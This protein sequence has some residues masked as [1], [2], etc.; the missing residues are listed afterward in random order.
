MPGLQSGHPFAI[1]DSARFT[2]RWRKSSEVPDRLLRIRSDHSQLANT[3]N[4]QT[5]AFAQERASRP[6]M[7]DAWFAT[8][9]QVASD[10]AARS[11]TR[12]KGAACWCRVAREAA[13]PQDPG[14]SVS[15]DAC[16]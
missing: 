9:A 16:L 4:G 3:A 15:I 13:R 12:V 14:S 6:A 1:T 10:K 8:Q 7:A 2:K 11:H 5:T